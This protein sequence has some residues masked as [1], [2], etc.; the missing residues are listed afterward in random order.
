MALFAAFLLF[1]FAIRQGFRRELLSSGI[2]SVFF[3]SSSWP[4]LIVWRASGP[5]SPESHCSFATA[6]VNLQIKLRPPC[7]R[8]V[9]GAQ[10]WEGGA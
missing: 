8:L 3:K 1:W 5:P 6:R 10:A 2:P 9:F 7:R 4:P